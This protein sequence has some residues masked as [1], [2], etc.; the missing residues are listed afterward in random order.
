MTRRDHLTHWAA[1]ALALA[2]GPASRAQP[3]ACR[4]ESPATPVALV[5]LFTSEGCSSCP[6]ADRWLSRATQRHG[7]RIVALSLHVKYW[8]Y[9][10]W[11]DPYAQAAFADR[12]RWLTQA[13]GGRTLYTPGVFVDGREWRGWGDA[14]LERRLAELARRPAGARLS[15]ESTGGPSA[16]F[17]VR[18]QAG[19]D[20]AGRRL[21]LMVA[22]TQSGLSSKVTAGENRGELLHHDHVVLR[23]GTPVPLDAAGRA[24]VD[25]PLG[26]ETAANDRLRLCAFVQDLADATVLQAVSMPVGA[27]C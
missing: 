8:D 1:G 12:Q 19:G 11:K 6:P 23:M 24:E 2:T 18:T 20:A 25:E 14:A 27:S 21:A 22:V 5:E 4:V 13:G 17:R 10:G 15:I 26:I 3:R 16:R 7:D 9:I